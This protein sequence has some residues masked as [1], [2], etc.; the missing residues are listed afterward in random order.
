MIK[1]NFDKN[2]NRAI[3]LDDGKIVGVCEY[4]ANIK[5]WNIVHTEVN[6]D[7]QGQGIAKGL[8]NCVI[9]NATSNNITLT[10]DCS[11]AKT[12][13]KNIKNANYNYFD[14]ISD[15]LK[16]YF[17]I[18]SSDIPDFLNDYINTPEMQKQANISVTCGTIYSKMFNIDMWYS[19]LDH[20]VAVALIV[21][22]FTKD[23]KQTL[24]GL[25]HDIATPVF[26]HCVDFMNGDHE[27]QESTEDKTRE[28][29]LNS[30]ELMALLNRD[31]IDIDEVC[32]YHI[33][34]IADNDTP[35]LS[36][37]RL[38]YTFSNGLGVRKY[39]WT[40]EEVRQV[41]DS[42]KTTTNEE[43][44]TEMC[45]TDIALAEK[46]VKNM[47]IL[48][49]SYIDSKTKL[50]MQ[51]FADILKTMANDNIIT[52]SDMYHK[53]ESE[54]IN[55]IESY[56]KH[57]IANVYNYWKTLDDVKESDEYIKNTYC[58]SI[59]AKIRYINPLVKIND[60]YKR[61]SKVSNEA[62]AAIDKALNYT[63][64]KYAYIDI[65]FTD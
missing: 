32:D 40:L 60:E 47:Q 64:K 23:K 10:A 14:T 20:S 2:N 5:Q 55:M 1:I 63:T 58:V 8:V 35:K 13:I 12:L 7:Y 49:S 39:L 28:I 15:Y 42:I 46:F 6:E 19:S 11:Y 21:W 45:F 43:G 24:S 30:K 48:S 56:T 9:E 61:I 65:N 51:L 18:L 53:S 54:V 3:A 22:H 36:A 34:P 33:Y 29:I 26:K 25:L 62:K 27:N 38:E 59:K 52:V 50:T 57:N 17:S 4:T 37:D 44:I 41:Y 16:E 31:G